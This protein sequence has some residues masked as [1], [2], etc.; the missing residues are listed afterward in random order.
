MREAVFEQVRDISVVMSKKFPFLDLLSRS[1]GLKSALINILC[2][3]SGSYH[4]H[5]TCKESL[6]AT[7]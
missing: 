1:I 3:N 6:S 5:L 4:L 2:I 7:N